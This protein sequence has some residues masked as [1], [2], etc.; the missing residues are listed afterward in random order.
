MKRRAFELR[1]YVIATGVFIAAVVVGIFIF[2]TCVQR[3]VEVNSREIMMTDVSRQ[4]EHMRTILDIHYQYL[5]EIASEMGQ[6]DELFSQENKDRL[7][8]LYEKT[9]L[10]RMALID[11]AGNAYYDNG[12]TKN[13]AH[14]RYFQEAIQGMQT[15]S[16]P[17]ES[18]VDQEIRVVLGVPVYK[19][20]EIIGVFGGSL[21]VGAL[22]RL[23]FADLFG[24]E[25]S[26]SI[27]TSEGD[28]IAFESGTASDRK[29]TYGT[30]MFEY[31]NEKNLNG[32]HTLESLQKQFKE[33]KTGLIKLSLG[34]RNESDRYLAYMPLGYN[35]WMI[36]YAV[37]VKAAQQDYDF[38][39][40][41]ELIFMG[42][43]CVL[44]AILILYIALRN[45]KE[46]AELVRSA[47]V[48]AL[49]G[50]YNKENTQKFIDSMLNIGSR[51]VLTGFMILDMDHFKEIN[52]TFG[53]AVGDKVLQSF[54]ALLQSQ[55]RDLDVVGRIGGD[56][57]V[58]LLYDIGSR[59]N[60]ER[61]VKSLQEKIREMEIPE[62]QG[63]K[64]T[65]S[66]GIA[67][68]PKDGNSF[69]ELYR[70]ADNA[71]YQTKRGGRDGYSVYEKLQ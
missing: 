12:V 13:V 7:V 69:M 11:T 53:H 3:S 15:I 45:N 64:L 28:V 54:G 17:L 8:S 58:V 36:C 44:V 39:S 60:M 70:R 34:E 22:S 65:S 27:V 67:F 10:E 29:V 16:D 5:N 66:A 30:N 35:D 46:K 24:G 4:S 21:N 9:E 42:S 55:F 57:F 23:L 41:Y 61:R 47:Q 31:Y 51:N 37:P 48:D 63:H 49:T 33:G 32:E 50:V 38:I 43:F 26:C 25:G 18:S 71:L 19:D 14:R 20:D 62:L 2:F 68:A 56:E 1:N 6:S 59:E 40:R 52:D